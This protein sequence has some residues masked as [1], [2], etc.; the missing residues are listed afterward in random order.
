M[1]NKLETIRTTAIQ[2]LNSIDSIN[3]LNEFKVKL[4]GRKGEMTLVLRGL[5]DIPLK[6][7]V[8]LES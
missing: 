4:L 8:R 2:E 6:K 3:S 7:G 1:Q 5:K